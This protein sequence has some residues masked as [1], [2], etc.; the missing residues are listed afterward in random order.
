MREKKKIFTM[1]KRN[2]GREI[3]GRIERWKIERKI[4]V[5]RE[6]NVGKR[7]GYE[8]KED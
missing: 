2:K 4:V 8:E 7:D 6:K 3:K 5:E 1:E